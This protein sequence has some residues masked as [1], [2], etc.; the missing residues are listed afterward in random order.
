MHS[1]YHRAALIGAALAVAALAA[2]GASPQP[3]PPVAAST[4][5][6]ALCSSLADEWKTAEAECSTNANLG[7]A[8]SLARE[9]ATKC[10]S[11]DGAQQKAGVGKYQSALRL[12]RK[13]GGAQ[14]RSL[15]SKLPALPSAD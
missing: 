4:D 14:I 13:S 7:R 8:R 6:T 15:G 3:L 10:K 5:D 2:F 11:P 12:C 1:L 9:A